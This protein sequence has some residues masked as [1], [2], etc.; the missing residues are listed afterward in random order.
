MIYLKKIPQKQFQY[1][2]TN[3]T[4]TWQTS[5]NQV[6]EDKYLNATFSGGCSA[7]TKL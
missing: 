3:L 7:L 1:Y 5:Q 2:L 6:N 4:N